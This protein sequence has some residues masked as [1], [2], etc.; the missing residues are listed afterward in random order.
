M[1]ILVGLIK[2]IFGVKLIKI[3]TIQNH[4]LSDESIK[5]NLSVKIIEKLN[6]PLFVKPANSGS[7]QGISKVSKKSELNK[8]LQKAWEIDTRIVIEEGVEVRE[9]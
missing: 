4:N 1:N 6:F 8:A 7:S 2:T 3:E 9:L 5:N